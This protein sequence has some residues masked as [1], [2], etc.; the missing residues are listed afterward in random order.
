MVC[1]HTVN[2]YAHPPPPPPVGTTYRPPLVLPLPLFISLFY[3]SLVLTPQK[4]FPGEIV[5]FSVD[6]VI[7]REWWTFDADRVISHEVGL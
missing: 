7:S 4:L 2:P 5:L 3:L 6:R 1:L